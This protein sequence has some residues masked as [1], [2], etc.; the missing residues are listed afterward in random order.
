MISSQND[1]DGYLVVILG[2]MFS[3]KT[4]RL[5]EIYNM[6]TICDI[7]CCVINYKEDTRYSKTKLVT[8]DKRGIPCIFSESLKDAINKNID[9]Y[10]VF[11]INEGQFFPD[12]YENVSYMVNEKNKKVYVCGLDGDYK[13]EK[14]GSILDLI[15][16]CDKFSKQYA[17]CKMCKN[18]T[19]AC[20][21]KRISC[22]KEQTVIGS[23]N[24][25]PVCRKCYEL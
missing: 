3:G 7:S 18:G 17:I 24:Y 5:L 23:T 16:L 6:Y 4:T 14:F 9:T 15:P 12:L 25:I 13:R 1:Q 20:F 2:C 21:S 11:L 22:E 19:K 10:N 8:H